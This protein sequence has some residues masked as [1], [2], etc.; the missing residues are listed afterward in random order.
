MSDLHLSSDYNLAGYFVRG[1]VR[2]VSDGRKTKPIKDLDKHGRLE[3][4]E[5]DL[6]DPKAWPAY[7]FCAYLLDKF[8]SYLS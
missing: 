2:S 4:V 5:A 3:L 8:K 7:V 6:N 1:T